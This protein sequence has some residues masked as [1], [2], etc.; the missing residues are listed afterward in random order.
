[1]QDLYIPEVLD[2]VNFKTGFSDDVLM[3][4]ILLS[5]CTFTIA[6]R[7]NCFVWKLDFGS[8]TIVTSKKVTLTLLCSAQ[9][10]RT[11]STGPNLS[12]L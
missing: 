12:R 1:M 10:C 11:V 8:G 3:Q 2:H 5:R 9:S 7:D 6:R 4:T